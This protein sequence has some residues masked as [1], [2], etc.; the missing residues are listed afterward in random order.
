MYTITPFKNRD[1]D[2]SK[3]V[4]IYRNLHNKKFSIKQNNKVIGYSE[5]ILLKDVN[6]IIQKYGKRK[7]IENKTRNVHAYVSG[8]IYD[9]E[10]ELEISFNEYNKKIRYNPF[11]DS[12][13]MDHKDN[14]VFYMEE[15]LL[16]Q[17]QCLYK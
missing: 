15:V 4:Y 7:A 3:K 1:L 6:F 5:I 16:Y 8:F 2:I 13:F 17:N 12:G 9:I 10:N 11:I 14:E